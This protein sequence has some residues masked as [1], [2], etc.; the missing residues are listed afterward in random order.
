MMIWIFH[1]Y[2]CCFTHLHLITKFFYAILL[3]IFFIDSM[4]IFYFRKLISIQNT[5]MRNGSPFQK[6]QKLC[7]HPIS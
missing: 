4:L 6:G 2:S 5:V 1:Y 3:R 7:S